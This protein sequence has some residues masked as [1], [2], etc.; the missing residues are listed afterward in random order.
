MTEPA[1]ITPDAAQPRKRE[2]SK[3]KF[4]TYSL[5]DSVK[6]A[7][8]LHDRGG[9]VV[10]ND[11]LAAYLGYRSAKNGAYLSRVASARTFDLVTGQGDRITIT[12]RAQLIL[13]PER[14]EDA[15]K[16]MVEAFLG[17]PLYRAI[18]DDN[19][20]KELPSEFGLKNAFRTRY[21]M[22]P[23]RVDEAYRALMDSADQAGFFQTKG[24]RSQLIIPNIGGARPAPAQPAKPDANGGSGGGD[25]GGPS[26][27]P[28]A[29]TRT[30]ADLQTEYVS[31]LIELLRQKGEPDPDLMQ[32]IEKLLGMPSG[33]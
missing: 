30:K 26:E 23:S 9:G 17:V 20:G 28:P 18:Y 13:M 29:Q 25:D 8:V 3:I 21:G 32:K 5:V 6:V 11:Q 7:Q 31:T 15:R 1:P 27:P 2:L 4:P 16:A 24:S 14:P 33:D 10:S 12:P 22:V 19:H